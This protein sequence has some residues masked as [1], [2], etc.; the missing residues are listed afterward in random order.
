MVYITNMNQ[1]YDDI[2]SS[3]IGGEA[4]KS[5]NDEEEEEVVEVLSDGNIM[6]ERNYHNECVSE[7]V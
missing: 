7:G 3:Q 4:P 5:N 6:N 1:K 2:E